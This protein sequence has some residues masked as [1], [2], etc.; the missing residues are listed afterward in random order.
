MTAYASG[1]YV[2]VFRQ[3]VFYPDVFGDIPIGMRHI[4]VPTL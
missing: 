3:I 1:I 4:R 2:V